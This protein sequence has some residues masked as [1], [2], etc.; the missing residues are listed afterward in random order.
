MSTRS[1]SAIEREQ[2]DVKVRARK[3]EDELDILARKETL[4]AGEEERFDNLMKATARISAEMADLAVEHRAASRAQ[5]RDAVASGRVTMEAGADGMDGAPQYMTNLDPYS[6]SNGE[7]PEEA[8][9]RAFKAVERWN[10]DDAIREAATKTLERVG[11]ST[12]DLSAAADVR[13]TAAHILR[14]GSPTYISAFRKYT[15]DPEGGFIADF[16]PDEARV[17][18]DARQYM[19]TTLDLSGAVVPSPLD[20]TIVITNTGT[21]D[22]M[23][24]VARLDTTVSKEKRYITSAGATFSWD[25][26]LA[27][28]SDDTPTL[29][30]VTITTQKAQGWIEASIEAAMDQPNFDVQVTN[31]FRDGKQRLEAE[32][33]INGTGGSNEPIG[34]ITRLAGSASEVDVVG[35]EV[36]AAADVYALIEALPP[37]WRANATWMA[38]LSTINEIDQFETT[39][40]A[41]L[42]PTVYDTNPSLLGRRLVENSEMDA[43][44]AVNVASTGN[45]FIA[46]VGDFQQ[47]VVL[48]RLGLVVNYVG[49]G[50]LVNSANLLPDGRVGFYGHWR[51]GS[52]RLTINAFRVLNLDTSGA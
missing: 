44:S 42:F 38:E 46:V 16:T 6:P 18:R 14:F 25:A 23:R 40:G 4:T 24:S 43:H 8:R 41:K 22:P 10:A 37:R 48:D 45:N 21:I 39:N 1:P 3:I 52:D 9:K 49:P 2:D 34:I 36:F 35:N 13:G 47:F 28:V 30:E 17:W 51:V 19:R 31:M 27:E 20:P 32:A 29:S 33:F 11:H 15:K 7:T 50:H 26:E 12:D 5:V